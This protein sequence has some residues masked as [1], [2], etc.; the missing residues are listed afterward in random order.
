MRS[1]WLTDKVL[2]YNR[3]LSLGEIRY[4]AGLRAKVDPG[5]EG[6]AVAYAFDV[7]YDIP[8]DTSGNGRDGTPLGDAYIEGGVLK[9]DGTGDAVA[10]PGIGE[11]NEYTFAM[12]VYPTEDL[13]TLQF[14]GGLNTDS[15]SGG[16][17]FKL[18]YGRVNVGVESV[19]GIIG[20]DVEGTTVVE[21]NMWTHIALTVSRDEIA[22]YVNGEKEG[23]RT[24]LTVPS[25]NIGKAAIGTW[26]HPNVDREMAG[27]M[28]NVLIYSRALSDEEILYLAGK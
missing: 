10:I 8:Y 19:W 7:D 1:I 11:V 12:Y 15:W 24:G 21:P 3:A 20:S 9:L 13:T 17:H 23:S 25:I 4:L 28:D 18:S 22:V 5:T 14:A 6:L 26:V 27:Q 2:I 16:V